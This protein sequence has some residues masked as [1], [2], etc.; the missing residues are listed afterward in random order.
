MELIFIT[1][2]M[3][4]VVI[5]H[6]IKQIYET[7]SEFISLRAMQLFRSPKT[8]HDRCVINIINK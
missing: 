4:R 2:F 1:I 3:I 8:I 5:L 6:P 7:E